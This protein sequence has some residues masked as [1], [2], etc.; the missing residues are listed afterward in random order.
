MDAET[1]LRELCAGW[2]RSDPAAVAALFAP[3]G[4]YE[5]PLFEEFPIGPEAVLAACTEAFADLAEVR[6]PLRNVGVGGDVALGE[7]TFAYVTT[8]GE[9]AEFPL[10]M[11]AEVRDGLLVRFTEYFDTAAVG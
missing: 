10:V 6:I 2:E 7:G 1:A 4:R 8:A 5:G 3:D 9:R 11:V